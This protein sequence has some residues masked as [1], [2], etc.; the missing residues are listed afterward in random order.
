MDEETRVGWRHAVPVGGYLY[1]GPRGDQVLR[2]IAHEFFNRGH[3]G[4]GGY[5]R[6]PVEQAVQVLRLRSPQPATIPAQP[7]SEGPPEPMLLAALFP[8]AD[9]AGLLVNPS[10]TLR[11]GR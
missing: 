8:I 1:V 10:F 9:M 7:V 11:R 6:L 5:R 2:R 4:D 3:P